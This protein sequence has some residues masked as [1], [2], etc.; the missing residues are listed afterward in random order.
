[1][2]RIF[3]SVRAQVRQRARRRCEYCLTL[4]TFSPDNFTMEH[5]LPQV[6]QGSNDTDNLALSCQQCNRNKYVA[7]AAIDPETTL[8]APLYNPRTDDWREHFR[9]SADFLLIEGVSPTGR[10][11]IASLDLNREGVV[12]LRRVLMLSGED[13]PP[14]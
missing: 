2:P 6:L 11:T 8:P 10:A 14:T 9:W 1:M 7:T 4:E 3:P 13:H 12:N 5:I